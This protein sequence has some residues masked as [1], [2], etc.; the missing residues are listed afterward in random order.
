MGSGGVGQSIDIECVWVTDAVGK[1]S[2]VRVGGPVGSMG[3]MQGM[4]GR[5][6]V[7]SF[8]WE[9]IRWWVRASMTE[10]SSKRQSI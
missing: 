4:V 5:A 9:M 8:V 2:T 7:S 10:S 1:G 6:D 3:R